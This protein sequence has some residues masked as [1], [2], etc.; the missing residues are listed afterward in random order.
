MSYLDKST[1]PIAAEL[2][3]A[4]ATDPEA[5]AL[6]EA[7]G[8]YDRQNH[9][10]HVR[11]AKQAA[12]RERRAAAVVELLIAQADRA[13]VVPQELT[14]ALTA[15]PAAKALFAQLPKRDQRSRAEHVHQGKQPATRERR[16]AKVVSSLHDKEARVEERKAAGTHDL[17]KQF[18]SLFV[19]AVA[20]MLKA[21]GFRRRTGPR[22]WI[23]DTVDDREDRLEIYRLRSGD[24]DEPTFR[25]E[26][27]VWVG[28]VEGGIG[29]TAQQL[30]DRWPPAMLWTRTPVED[31]FRLGPATD[32]AALA[33]DLLAAVTTIVETFDAIRPDDLESLLETTPGSW[34][35]AGALYD[36]GEIERAREVYLSGRVQPTVGEPDVLGQRLGIAPE[37]PG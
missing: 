12:T 18:D 36:C 10:E 37:Q 7:M 30:A 14:D 25:L 8:Y 35:Q 33:A 32:R 11:M 15:D 1:Q 9:S 26:P 28:P 23:R 21:A 13:G 34:R 27:W 2:T 17:G 5:A 4:L 20:P 3:A 16:A 29:R 22:H 24:P 6:F 31:E 19:D